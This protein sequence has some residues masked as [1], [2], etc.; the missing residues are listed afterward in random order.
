MKQKLILTL[1][2]LLLAAVPATAQSFEVDGICYEITDYFF[3]ANDEMVSLDH[4]IAIVTSYCG[5]QQDVIIP[6]EVSYEGGTY[7]VEVIGQDAFYHCEGLTSVVIPNSVTYIGWNAFAYCFDLTSVTIGNS[8]TTIGSDA[9][10]GCSS[11]TNID[12]PNSVTYIGESA[13]RECSG[14]TSV[15]IPNSVTYIGYCTFE[16]CYNL[17]DVYS[18]I[19]DLSCVSVNDAF[20]RGSGEEPAEECTLHVPYGK[21]EEYQADENWGPYFSDIVEMDAEVEDPVLATSIALEPTEAH[22]LAGETLQLRAIIEPE[23]V[24]NNSVSWSTSDP[25]IATV[26]KN[27]LVTAVAEGSAVITVTTNDGTQL[28]ASCA[29]TVEWNNITFADA[30]VKTICVQNWDTNG[31]G[32]LSDIEAAAV[33]SLDGKFRSNSTITSFDELQYFTGLTSIEGSSFYY[34]WRLKS[35]TIPNSV[36]SIGESAFENCSALKGI[37]IPNSVTSIGERAFESCSALTGIVIPNS[38]TYIRDYTFCM[39]SNLTSVDIPNSVTYIG[40]GAF[41][42]CYHLSSI[43]IPNSVTSIQPW[44]FTNCCSLTSIDIPN[45]VTSIGE[46]AFYGCNGLK[47]L[48]LGKSVRSIHPRAFSDCSALTTISVD[49]ANTYFDSRDN[50]NAVIETASNTLRVGCKNTIIPNTVTAIGEGAFEGCSHLTSIDVPNSVTSIGNYAFRACSELTS[51]VIPNSVTSIGINA[52]GSCSSL[53]SI[54]IPNS[55][56]TIGDQ[57]FYGCS[58]LTS[59]IIPNSVTSIG[60]MVFSG[61]SSLTSI[62]VENGNPIYDSRDNCNAVIRTS[63]NTLVAGCKNTI[64]P[65]SVTAIDWYAFYWCTGLTSI[66]IPNS[67][68]T[69]GYKVFY[70]CTGLTSI[71][72]PNSVTTIG[73]DAFHGCSALTSIDIPNSVTKI[74]G[75]AFY[76]CSNLTS[77]TIPNSVTYIGRDAFFGCDKLTDVYSYITDLSAVSMINTIFSLYSGNYSGRTLH[78]PAGMVEVYQAHNYWGPYFG[79]IVEMEPEVTTPGDVDGDGVVGISDVTALIDM[80]LTDSV[81]IEDY[82]AADVNGDGMIN[83]ADVTEL[84]D[85]I[86]TAG[87]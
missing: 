82:P 59:I 25:S 16:G 83:I 14:L 51:I 50:C 84:I 23:D 68:T 3:D 74:N 41:S 24:T 38:V 63:S 70:M 58:I 1:L 55:V 35:V 26:D 36:K 18:Y 10:C 62:I 31:D 72:I 30:N 39:C 5:E 11:L 80:I 15:T 40:E 79:T 27:G 69:I 32:E 8:V 47:S 66:V 42:D 44:T 7:T 29:V 53:T 85:R 4:D 56:T 76:S 87:L 52:F 86:L 67:V 20:N 60:D 54:D 73:S 34:C 45:S 33:K 43:I 75:N 57:A 28:S 2:L 78:V 21:V 6:S 22:L 77:V 61:C 17:T 49:P 64:I 13:F 48:T 37:V 19:T 9:F 65:N 71:V 12:I 46:V 81:S